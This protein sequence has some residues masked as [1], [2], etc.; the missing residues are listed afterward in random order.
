MGINR[1]A[2]NG[3]QQQGGIN[4]EANNGGQQQGGINREANNRED[5][6]VYGYLCLMAFNISCNNSHYFSNI[7]IYI[8]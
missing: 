3:G 4:R 5:N 8:E 6:M 2:N 7:Y 1:E